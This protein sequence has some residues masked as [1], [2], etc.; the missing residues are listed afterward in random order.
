MIEWITAAFLIVGTIFI[1]L[2]SLGLLR[3]PDFYTRLHGPTKAATL[4][5]GLVLVGAVVYFTFGQQIFSIR[6]ILVIVFIFL[7]APVGSHMLAKA[8]RAKGVEF[9]KDTA[10]ESPTE[11]EK[12]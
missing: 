3:L 10:M 11:P 1:A 8:A 2:S 9:H 5:V 7:T 6:E 4:G 12:K